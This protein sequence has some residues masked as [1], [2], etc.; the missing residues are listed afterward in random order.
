[1]SATDHPDN[2]R[3]DSP[4][5]AR[6]APPPLHP[7][8]VHV[9][10]FDLDAAP[11]DLTAELDAGE[12]SRAERYRDGLRRERAVA[13]QGTL[14]RILGA[15][16]GQKPA[17]LS[18]RRGPH[19]K[20]AVDGELEFNLSHSRNTALLAVSVGREVGVDLEYQRPLDTAGR[21]A[22]RFFTEAEAATLDALPLSTRQQSFYRAWTRKEALLKAMGLG[23]AGRLRSVEVAVDGA[24][25]PSWRALT[26]ETAG[27]WVLRDLPTLEGY[28]AAVAADSDGWHLRC[29][30]WRG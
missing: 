29:M 19:G 5:P 23:I 24:E 22:R 28:A 30:V 10:R 11:A 14:R 27:A 3:G 9:W 13:A 6:T 1:M 12:R 8:E 18:F 26:A 16:L 21:L 20:P 17:G 7:D 2:T 4:W 25:R 15:Y